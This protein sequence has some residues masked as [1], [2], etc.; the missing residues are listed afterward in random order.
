MTL[1][2]C[3]VLAIGGNE[4]VS[5]LISLDFDRLLNIVE[6]FSYFTSEEIYSGDLND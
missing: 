6:H 1:G 4:T 2:G 5:W 3:I